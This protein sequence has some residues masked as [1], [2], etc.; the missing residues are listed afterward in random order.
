VIG[1]GRW[2]VN[3]VRVLRT[4]PSCELLYL[5]DRSAERRAALSRQYPGVRTAEDLSL[6]LRDPAVQA[7]FI[8]TP[9]GSHYAQA[10]LALEAGKAV[11][12]EKPLTTCLREAQLLADLAARRQRVL[13]VGHIYLY[14]PC[15]AVLQKLLAGSGLGDHYSI[16]ARR[17]NPGPVRD[18]VHVAW[19]L[20]CH[21][22]ALALFL[23]KC[24][25][26][27]VSA[28]A[29]SLRIP[30]V[31]DVVEVTLHF[32]DETIA[33]LEVGW[34]HDRKVRQFVVAGEDLTI[35]FDELNAKQPLTVSCEVLGGR[36]PRLCP[37]WEVPAAAGRP[38]ADTAV[39]HRP[40]TGNTAVAHRPLLL[41]PAV[42]LSEPLRLE[43]QAFLEAVH[44]DQPPVSDARLGVEVVRVLEAIDRSIVEGASCVVSV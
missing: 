8:A 1:L 35:R 6:A 36:V 44:H 14:H 30:G 9:A 4:E 18:D 22:I 27:E 29:E 39:T 5:C 28:R 17:L 43:C 40:P 38:T 7:V 34:I 33:N 24:P 13:M 21:D 11:F 10:R 41:I 25:A 42:P 31:P 19:D 3:L 16:Y 23:K 37:P 32:A 15:V 20:A 26:V 12:V 2:G